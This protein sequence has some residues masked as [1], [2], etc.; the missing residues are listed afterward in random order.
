MRDEGPGFSPEDQQQL[1]QKYK[2]LS[3]QPT[4]GESSHGLGLA[5][6]KTLVTHLGATIELV[7]E[8]RQEE[9]GSEFV[10]TF[11]VYEEV[12]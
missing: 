8:A 5:I 4:K 11:P 6:V 12:I 7:S 2:R 9:G 10:I 3:A 1:Y